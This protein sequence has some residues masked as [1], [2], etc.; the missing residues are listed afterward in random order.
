M[1]VRCESCGVQ[2][3]GVV[4]VLLWTARLAGLAK[5]VQ[6]CV[7]MCLCARMGQD[8]DQWLRW[9]LVIIWMLPKLLKLQV[10][11]LGV[12]AVYHTALASLAR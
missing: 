6:E 8:R 3:V 4:R 10:C 9:F 12:P 11:S 7:H 1:R 5:L 2:V